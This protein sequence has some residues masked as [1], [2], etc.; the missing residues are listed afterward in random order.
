[1]ALR[2][3]PSQPRGEYTRYGDGPACPLLDRG[4]HAGAG[5]AVERSAYLSFGDDFEGYVAFLRAEIPDSALVALPPQS[6]STT[7]G[8]NGLM[9]YFLFPRRIT[10]CPREATFDACAVHLGGPA[11]YIL[12]VDGF[13]DALPDGLHKRYVEY[14]PEYGV[15]VPAAAGGAE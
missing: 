2:S 11:T 14:G 3:Q 10:N 7:F 5:G 13:P 8:H 4:S 9:Q 6:V 12:R 15:Y 1:M